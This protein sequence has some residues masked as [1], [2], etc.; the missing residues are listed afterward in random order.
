MYFSSLQAAMSTVMVGVTD[1]VRTGRGNRRTKA[2]PEA[3]RPGD[4]VPHTPP[5]P[6]K[7][8]VSP[9]PSFTHRRP[10]FS[11]PPSRLASPH[12]SRR[13]DGRGRRR[14]R[15]LRAVAGVLLAARAA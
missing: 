11:P 8:Y 14:G 1:A 12:A 2:T 13:G 3:R 5:P 6:P 4:G 9:C 7:K 15:R 10:T